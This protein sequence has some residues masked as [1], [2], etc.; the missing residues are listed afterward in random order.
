MYRDL[1]LEYKDDPENKG[2]IFSIT[3]ELFL[4]KYFKNASPEK[5]FYPPFV[6]GEIYT[7]NYQTDAKISEDRPFIDRMPL[8]LCTNVF[9]TKESGTIVKG[10]DLITVPHRIR[11]DIIG[12]IYDT[13]TGQIKDNEESYDKG[14]VKSPVNLK[15]SNLAILLKNTGYRNALFGFKYKFIREP[16]V[17]SVSDWVKIPYLR[18]NSI[19]GLPI[20]GIYKEY[21]SKLI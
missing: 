18:V 21:Q 20:Q 14:G 6:P 11:I 7:F 12:K 16:K 1:V 10:I 17:I 9:D 13:F 5:I 4:N 19:E 3:D 8:V 2:D 15:D